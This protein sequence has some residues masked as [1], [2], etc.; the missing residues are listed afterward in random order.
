MK[1]KL[2][3][4][5]DVNLQRMKVP[6]EFALSRMYGDVV[7]IEHPLTV[8]LPM[9]N[10]VGNRVT[11]CNC[12]GIGVFSIVVFAVIHCY[13]INYRKG[14]RNSYTFIFYIKSI[15]HLCRFIPVITDIDHISTD[16]QL[17]HMITT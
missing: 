10:W 7:T 1:M 15:S 17:F 8:D 5:T 16:Q 3:V 14:M 11:F 4:T 2:L 13:S 12:S 9:E 6:T